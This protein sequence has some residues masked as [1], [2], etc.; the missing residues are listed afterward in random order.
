MSI[1]CMESYRWRY[2]KSFTVD[3][4]QEINFENIKC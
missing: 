1:R 2:K 4:S 3:G